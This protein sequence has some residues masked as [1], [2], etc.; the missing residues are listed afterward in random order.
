M[1]LKT[2][3]LLISLQQKKLIFPITGSLFGIFRLGLLFGCYPRKIH[4]VPWQFLILHPD[5]TFLCRPSH[6]RTSIAGET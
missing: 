4:F 1:F 6:L 3:F 5:G 2:Y